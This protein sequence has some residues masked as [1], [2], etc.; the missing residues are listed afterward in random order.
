MRV[1]AVKNRV[2]AFDR[3]IYQFLTRGMG[4]QSGIWSEVPIGR[5]STFH[6]FCELHDASLF[7]AIEKNALQEGNCTQALQL[8]L[9]AVA[10]E[11]SIKRRSYYRLSMLLDLR[12]PLIDQ[13]T[14]SL[15][16]LKMSGIALFLER[17]SPALL[18]WCWNAI[19]TANSTSLTTIW[20][21]V[22]KNLLIS[23]CTCINPLLDKYMADPANLGFARVQPNLAFSII[24]CSCVTHVVISWPD[25]FNDQAKWISDECST[26]SGFERLV[27]RFA[28][29][30]SEDTSL[31]PQFWKQLSKKARTGLA[32][33]LA[34]RSDDTT[35]SAIPIV[36]KI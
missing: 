1:I 31:S 10:Y 12:G 25:I 33:L 35:Y 15:V 30:E 22:P 26:P 27:N 9:R 7:A 20:R 36:V 29:A 34:R 23:T 18:G 32:L 24:P 13:E 8:Y 19:D 16:E 3:N 21:A 6:G 28:F 11:T 2:V 14:S 4:N 17:D 5:V